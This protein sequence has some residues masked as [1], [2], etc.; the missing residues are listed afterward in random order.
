MADEKELDPHA[1]RFIFQNLCDWMNET[2]LGNGIADLM[3]YFDRYGNAKPGIFV[4]YTNENLDPNYLTSI[5]EINELLKYHHPGYFTTRKLKDYVFELDEEGNVDPTDINLLRIVEIRQAYIA[6]YN[7]R[8][9]DQLAPF[10]VKDAI[11]S[12]IP[13][14]NSF[15]DP[16]GIKFNVSDFLSAKVML[17]NSFKE[18][19][20][21]IVNVGLILYVG[22]LM[23]SSNNLGRTPNLPIELLDRYFNGGTPDYLEG[24]DCKFYLDDKVQFGYPEF[25]KFNFTVPISSR[26]LEIVTEYIRP[27]FSNLSMTKLKELARRYILMYMNKP[28]TNKKLTPLEALN[29]YY[30]ETGRPNQSYIPDVG[31]SF[32]S[33]SNLLMF[34]AIPEDMLSNTSKEFL[35]PTNQRVRDRLE[36]IGAYFSKLTNVYDA[37]AEASQK[38]EVRRGSPVVRIT[39]HEED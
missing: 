1:P 7:S 12:L 14:T 9:K 3:C 28:K 27:D 16:G 8:H 6:T 22:A 36:I 39:S 13:Q 30:K 18:Y 37:Y 11:K 21:S 24:R 10:E 23:R 2:N 17:K 19:T 5:G 26:N 32:S 34:Y 31:L 20:S 25:K 4:E 33:L 38:T 15:Y 29:V 35:D